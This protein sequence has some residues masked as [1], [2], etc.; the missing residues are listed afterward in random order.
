M[1]RVTGSIVSVDRKSGPVFY[2][3]ARD[4]TGRQIKKRLG[5]EANWS[6]RQRET[7][8][9]EFLVDLGRT[10]DGPEHEITIADAARAWLRYVE[11]EK[12]RAASTVR[13]YRNTMNNSIVP[14]F[15]KDKPLTAIERDDIDDFRLALLERVS[16]RTAQKT[17]VLLYGML[18]YA[19]RKR[20]LADNPAEDAERVSLRHRTEFAVLSPSEVHAVA[21]CAASAG[22]R[23]LWRPSR[24]SDRASSG[25]CAGG[26][27]TSSIGSSTCAVRS[28]EGR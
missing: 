20:W 23:R 3:K 7:A 4:R 28:G 13:D 10:P 11:H 22:E 12:A 25:P 26:T 21:R 17:L 6:K 19:K 8:L 9:R 1:A 5:P 15:D 27:S 2:I 18:K 14:Y 16:R 24:G